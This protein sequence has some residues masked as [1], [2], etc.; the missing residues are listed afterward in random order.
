MDAATSQQITGLLQ[1]WGRGQSSALDDLIPHV[2][3]EL[4]RL[5]RRAQKRGGLLQRC[6][7]KAP[8]E[9]FQ[10]ALELRGALIPV[11]RACGPGSAPL[12]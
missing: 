6:L 9:R 7:A 5:A 3:R 1:A 4:N 10:S 2:Y 12:P 8:E 11:L